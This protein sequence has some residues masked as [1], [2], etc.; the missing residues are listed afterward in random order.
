MCSWV[1]RWIPYHWT[2][3]EVPN[4]HFYFY[5]PTYIFK[6]KWIN[7][8][9]NKDIGISTGANIGISTGAM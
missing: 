1:G 3:R 6:T 2:T 5:F 8:K 7:Q 4:I 9:L